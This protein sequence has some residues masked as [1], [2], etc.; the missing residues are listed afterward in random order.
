MLSTSIHSS[1]QVYYIFCESTHPVHTI[2]SPFNFHI[3]LAL[4]VNQPP[5]IF[6]TNPYV[7]VNVSLFLLVS[8]A[9]I[10]RRL[11]KKGLGERKHSEFLHVSNSLYT[12]YL[13][14]SL[15]IKSLAHFFSFKYIKYVTPLSPACGITVE[16]VI[17]I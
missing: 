11:L 4:Q 6:T 7:N 5:V 12:L 10:C 13:I 2:L 15:D 16:N 9:Q 8:E 1:F 17:A 3:A 14:A